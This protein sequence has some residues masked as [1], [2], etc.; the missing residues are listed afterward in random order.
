MDH[1]AWKGLLILVGTLAQVAL[2]VA[3][4]RRFLY[5]RKLN[6]PPKDPPQPSLL[7]HLT[8]WA[9]GLCRHGK[10]HEACSWCTDAPDQK[11]KL[12]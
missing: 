2:C 7:Y 9:S 10:K 8:M 4:V 5:L 1:E 6:A 12:V 3:M 11:A